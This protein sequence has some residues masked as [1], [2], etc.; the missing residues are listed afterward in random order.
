MQLGNQQ[1]TVR[2]LSVTNA[3][4]GELHHKL[5]SVWCSPLHSCFWPLELGLV[6]TM[7]IK[8]YASEAF[9][10]FYLSGSQH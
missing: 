7:A 5:C 2:N 1:L 4:I 9:S 8:L 6:A 3:N 10:R